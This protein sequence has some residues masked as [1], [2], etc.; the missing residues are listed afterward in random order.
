MVANRENECAAKGETG[1]ELLS[2]VPGADGPA[3][4]VRRGSGPPLYV[5]RLL[6]RLCGL[7]EDQSE[8]TILV[9]RLHLFRVNCIGQADGSREAA[10]GAFSMVVI[11]PFILFAHVLLAV[12]RENTALYGHVD[13]LLIDT[14]KLCGN[15][16]RTFCLH[17]IHTGRECFAR[18]A[19]TDRHCRAFGELI[20]QVVHASLR[21]RS[22]LR[23]SA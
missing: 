3:A 4:G 14:R 7:R 1:G 20:A 12:Y 23:M 22:A 13:V 21:K 18:L 8:D 15:Q 10:V 19:H 16:E 2:G 9:H 6:Q 17:D 5:L 11:C